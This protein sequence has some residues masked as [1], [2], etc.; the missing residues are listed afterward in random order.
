[1]ISLYPG[2]QTHI[3]Q[4]YVLN[5]LDN[6]DIDIDQKIC[7]SDWD[8]YTLSL[9]PKVILKFVR[10]VNWKLHYI[11][12]LISEGISFYRFKRS[13]KG[14]PFKVYSKRLS[15]EIDILLRSPSQR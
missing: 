12:V 11:E 3:Y 10:E 1:M 8:N 15:S 9:R 14:P 5:R 2:F 13:T 4:V 7:C 6:I